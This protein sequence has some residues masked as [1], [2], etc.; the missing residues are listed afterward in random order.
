L[1]SKRNVP[2]CCDLGS[3]VVLKISHNGTFVVAARL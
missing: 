1:F 2:I 3:W